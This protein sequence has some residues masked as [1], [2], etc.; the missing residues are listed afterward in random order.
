MPC[1]S[2]F[3]LPCRCLP[4]AAIMSLIRILMLHVDPGACYCRNYDCADGDR[5]HRGRWYI[6][7][8]VMVMCCGP[9][10][11][12]I[13]VVAVGIVVNGRDGGGGGGGGGRIGGGAPAASAA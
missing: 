12:S 8:I 9:S 10:S 4:P 2:G 7:L 13:A 6:R 11:T 5:W 3:R 1:L